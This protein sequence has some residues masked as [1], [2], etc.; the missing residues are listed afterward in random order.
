MST[1]RNRLIQSFRITAAGLTVQL[2][3]V[4]GRPQELEEFLL[5]NDLSDRIDLASEPA[6]SITPK[7][8][9]DCEQLSAA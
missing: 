1:A 3:I 7:S 6:S 5:E 9:A 2:R 8:T 4:R